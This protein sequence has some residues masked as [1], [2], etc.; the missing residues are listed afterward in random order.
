VS[1]NQSVASCFRV[2]WFSIGKQRATRGEGLQLERT[3]MLISLLV[4]LVIT[5]R[6]DGF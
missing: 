5:K 2:F 4:R 3:L 6:L 1:F